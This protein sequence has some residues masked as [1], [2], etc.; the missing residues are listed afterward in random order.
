MKTCDNGEDVIVSFNHTRNS[1]EFFKIKGFINGQETV[2][3]DSLVDSIQTDVC[4]SKS[5]INEGRN[6]K[7][8]YQYTLECYTT[9]GMPW[10]KSSIL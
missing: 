5:V 8:T 6:K 1:N 9:E 7:I 4:I 3:Y 2:I 10:A